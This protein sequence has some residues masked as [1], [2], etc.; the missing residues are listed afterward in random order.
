VGVCVCGVGWVGGLGGVL[1]GFGF[2]GVLVVELV[3]F[4]VGFGEGVLVCGC[5]VVGCGVLVGGWLGF[6]FL[7]GGGCLWLLGFCGCRGVVGE[8]CGLWVLVGVCLG[9]WGGKRGWVVCGC[10]L[11]V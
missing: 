5:V 9:G 8:C 2:V 10:V 3:C 4:F 1:W 6:C 7:V 11:G